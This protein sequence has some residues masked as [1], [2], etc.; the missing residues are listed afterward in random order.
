MLL[1]EVYKRYSHLLC[2]IICIT[3]IQ[4]QLFLI[5]LLCGLVYS[6]P[7][8]VSVTDNDHTQSQTV[9]YCGGIKDQV[10]LYI[11]NLCRYSTD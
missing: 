2:Y 1:Q 4:T 11:T 7:V 8:H 9:I 3:K 5:H 6:R 10:I